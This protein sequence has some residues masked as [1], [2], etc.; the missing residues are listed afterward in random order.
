MKYFYI[1]IVGS[2]GNELLERTIYD[3]LIEGYVFKHEM[4]AYC[5]PNGY[6]LWIA[7]RFLYEEG[8]RKDQN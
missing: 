8:I 4:Q 6:L 7:E 3:M 5:N 1:F 2:G